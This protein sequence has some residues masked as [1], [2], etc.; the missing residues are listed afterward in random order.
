MSTTFENAQVGDK[1]WSIQLGDCTITAINSPDSGVYSIQAV[2]ERT[3][4][5]SSYTIA[6]RFSKIDSHHSLFWSNPNIIAPEEPKR[7]PKL[8][9]D[10]LCIVGDGSGFAFWRYF[11]HYDECGRAK[12]F[13]A[14]LTSLTWPGGTGNT[15]RWHEY[16]LATPEEIEAR[17]N[18]T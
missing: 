14:G 11:S 3:G 7:L 16:R 13:D 12:F 2:S 9:R 15:S 6:G 10:D 17:R 4:R 18:R 5:S 8:K 1:A